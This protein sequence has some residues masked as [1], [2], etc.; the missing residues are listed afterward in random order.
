ME[1]ILS[2]RQLNILFDGVKLLN[3]QSFSV[4]KPKGCNEFKDV[5]SKKL[6]KK[7]N[8]SSYRHITTPVIMSVLN[9]HKKKWEEGVAEESKNK[10]IEVLNKLKSTDPNKVWRWTNPNPKIRI[11]QQG[12]IEDL[13]QKRLPQLSFIYTDDKWDQ[14]NKL[15]TNYSDTAILITDI[16]LRNYGEE[17]AE[18]VYNSLVDN[19]TSKLKEI[20]QKIQNGDIK[21][22]DE[23]KYN[24]ER[25]TQN[26]TYNSYQ[27]ELIEGIVLDFLLTKGFTL[28]HRGSGGDPIDVLL[29]I[30]LIMEKDGKIYTFQCKKVFNISF[31]K[32]TIMNPEK[33]AYK[34]LSNK[35]LY[36]SKQPNLDYVAYGTE[37]G[38]VLIAKKQ[39][40]I[41]K[42]E[43]GNGFIYLDKET[44][45][46][47]KNIK[48]YSSYESG[49][50][51]FYVDVDSVILK[52][53][54]I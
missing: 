12:N 36:I 50:R 17:Y 28:I 21:I 29:G 33:G 52:T 20:V 11:P 14:I 53:N 46:Q 22:F 41:L 24:K 4:D 49:H 26:S 5:S 7:L 39:Y 48:G 23:I 6:C 16:I 37:N 40:D 42:N 47:P 32:S 35:N 27:G 30:D 18:E 44:F 54:D 10:T 25:Y 15:D 8:S 3:E 31:E 9:S 19:D 34:I 43:K 13:I 2:E 1:Y 45:A 51:V 38:S